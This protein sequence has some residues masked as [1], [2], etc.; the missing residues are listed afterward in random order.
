VTDSDND[1]TIVLD[2]SFDYEWLHE[3]GSGFDDCPLPHHLSST[4]EILGL[5]ENV[6][7]LIS[8]LPRPAAIIIA[9]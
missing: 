4:E 1:D 8:R 3:I 2:D 6:K 5:L 9:R 7:S